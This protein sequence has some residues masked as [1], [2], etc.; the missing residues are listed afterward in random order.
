MTRFESNA[1]DGEFF[2]PSRLFVTGFKVSLVEC[3]LGC[4]FVPLCIAKIAGMVSFPGYKALF[5]RHKCFNRNGG[6]PSI[7]FVGFVE[8]F[9]ET[10]P[11]YRI[12]SNNRYRRNNFNFARRLYW[13]RT[14][15][16]YFTSIITITIIFPIKSN[17]FSISSNVQRQIRF[18]IFLSS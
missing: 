1:D 4:S 17:N 16:T 7:S 6:V 2:L 3:F 14:I 10:C 9:R 18:S 11:I 15:R 13:K 12:L 8:K 5:H